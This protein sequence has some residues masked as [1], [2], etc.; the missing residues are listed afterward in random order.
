MCNNRVIFYDLETTGLDSVN[1]SI[2]EIAGKDNNGNIFSGNTNISGSLN[3]LESVR[4]NKIPN[5]VYITS[6]KCY[7][8]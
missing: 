5:L 7:L 6:D 8:I 1:D 3:I 4:I 2:I